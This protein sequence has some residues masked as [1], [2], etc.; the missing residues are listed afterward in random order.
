[1]A[2]VASLIIGALKPGI[3]STQKKEFWPANSCCVIVALILYWMDSSLGGLNLKR[4]SEDACKI[5]AAASH[6][7]IH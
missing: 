2:I 7:I 4:P 1:M 5:T 6:W 3:M